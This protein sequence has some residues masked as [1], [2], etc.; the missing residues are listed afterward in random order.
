MVPRPGRVGEFTQ[1]S[2]GLFSHVRIVPDT[3][4]HYNIALFPQV[5]K[6]EPVALPENLNELPPADPA[7]Y[8]APPAPRT[9]EEAL[10]QRL[11]KFQVINL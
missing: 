6:D 10:L 7:L 1:P 5:S 4:V 9:V 8:G 11:E 3:E 2:L